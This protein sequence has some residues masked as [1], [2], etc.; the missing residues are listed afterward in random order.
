MWRYLLSATSTSPFLRA[1]ELEKDAGFAL[2]WPFEGG[3]RWIH[4]M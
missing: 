3:K 1:M 4:P 2:T